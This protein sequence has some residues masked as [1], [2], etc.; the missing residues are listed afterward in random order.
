MVEIE[1]VLRVIK[2]LTNGI[3]STSYKDIWESNVSCR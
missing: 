1:K 2:I 3:W